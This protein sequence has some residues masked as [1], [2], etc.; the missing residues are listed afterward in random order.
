MMLRNTDIA[1]NQLDSS[2]AIY[3]NM[4]NVSNFL[5]MH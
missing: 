3:V 5:H 1:S 2:F 4:L